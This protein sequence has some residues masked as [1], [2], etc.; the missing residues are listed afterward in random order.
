[1]KKTLSILGLF[2]TLALT[3][4]GSS[5]NDFY[6]TFTSGERT[7]DGGGYRVTLH[8]SDIGPDTYV[9]APMTYQ[10]CGK[11]SD[12]LN[13]DLHGKWADNWARTTKQ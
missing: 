11:L 5:G 4:C 8:T 12:H 1:M 9:S 6:C 3:G 13:T 10:D 2:L 7:L